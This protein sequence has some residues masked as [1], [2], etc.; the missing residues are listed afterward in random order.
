MERTADIVHGDSTAEATSAAVF[1]SACRDVAAFTGANRVSIWCFGEANASLHCECLLDVDTETFSQGQML[2]AKDHPNY[3]EAI[4][5]QLYIVAPDART[6]PV[7]AEFA[8]TYFR[9]HDI[10]SLLDF[11]L[12]RNFKP[13]GILCC[14][15]AGEP[16][17]WRDEDVTYLRQMST[18]ISF[19]FKREGRAA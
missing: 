3:F 12:H 17:N 13:V 5:R 19:F 16:R 9:D 6:H 10:Y 15:H 1:Q 4:Q 14:E 2:W 7:T 8:D 18:L 11:I